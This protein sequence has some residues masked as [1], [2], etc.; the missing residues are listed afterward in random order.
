MSNALSAAE[1]RSLE[2][3]TRFFEAGKAHDLETMKTLITDDFVVWYNFNDL[4][5]DRPAFIDFMTKSYATDMATEYSD[6]RIVPSSSG[7]VEEGALRLTIEG[8]EHVARF[9]LVGTLRGGKLCRLHEY[10]DSK[11]MPGGIGK[12]GSR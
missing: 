3:A 2:V 6:I 1:A 4:R 10:F 8:R 9:C 5:L 12:T 7:F 11:D